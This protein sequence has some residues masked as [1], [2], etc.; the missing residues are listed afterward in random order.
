MLQIT[1]FPYSVFYIYFEQYL[2]IVKTTTVSLALALAA[3]FIVCLIT[4]SS[5]WTAAIIVSVISM[6]IVDLLGLMVVWDIQLNAVSVVNLV[7]S[8]GIAVEFCVH[9]T[10]AFTMSTGHRAAR[11]TKALLTMGASVFRYCSFA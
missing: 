6:I 9:I 5:I 8:V 2:N 3:V 11:A 1:V 10:H 7:M 4:T